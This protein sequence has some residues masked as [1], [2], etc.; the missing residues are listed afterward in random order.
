MKICLVGAKVPCEHISEQAKIRNLLGG[1]HNYFP[2]TPENSEHGSDSTKA[3][4]KI[5]ITYSNTYN[6]RVTRP[7]FLT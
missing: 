6:F 7:L 4:T 3:T 5:N 1:F 2:H